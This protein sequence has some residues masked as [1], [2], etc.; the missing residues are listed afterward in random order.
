MQVV[1][2]ATRRKQRVQLL[3]SQPQRGDGGG[4]ACS[5]CWFHSDRQQSQWRRRPAC[6]LTEL[7]GDDGEVVPGV[8]L[9]VQLPQDV[10]R[11]VAGVHVEDSVHVGAP[12]DGVPA[13]QHTR[14]GKKKIKNGELGRRL[15]LVQR[16][17][18]A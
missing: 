10:D 9:A 17:A 6:E 15:N 4:T 16:G 18:R 13:A 14:G 2:P 1:A 11:A 12:V 3:E 8:L 7:G 5:C